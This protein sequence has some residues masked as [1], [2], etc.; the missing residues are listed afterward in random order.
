MRQTFHFRPPQKHAAVVWIIADLVAYRMQTQ[1]GLSLL[2][3]TDFLRRA[4]WKAYKQPDDTQQ[5][6]TWTVFN[7]LNAELN[8]TCHLLALLGDHHIHHV[9]RIRVKGP[10]PVGKHNTNTESRRKHPKRRQTG[11]ENNPS[12]LRQQKGTKRS[13]LLHHAKNSRTTDLK[14]PRTQK[15]EP[16]KHV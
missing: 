9:S 3:Y 1:K 10:P 8:P 7:P 4:R 6:I 5:A 15:Q 13:H 14:V 11:G 16:N 12:P 2:D